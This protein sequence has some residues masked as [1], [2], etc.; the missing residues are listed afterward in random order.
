MAN[1]NC[2][3]IESSDLCQSLF[4]ELNLKIENLNWK[5]EQIGAATRRMVLFSLGQV[6]VQEAL[7]LQFG[8]W[9]IQKRWGD[10][11][12]QKLIRET[13]PLQL[14]QTSTAILRFQA[15]IKLKKPPICFLPNPTPFPEDNFKLRHCPTA[16]VL[17]VPGFC[18]TFTT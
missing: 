11:Q 6:T 12:A 3:C 16:C 2:A 5:K 18:V 10:F 1:H 4:N 7:L 8:S 17:A 9:A 15:K 14:G 13:R